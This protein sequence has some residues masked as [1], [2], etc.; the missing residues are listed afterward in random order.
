MGHSLTLRARPIWE[1]CLIGGVGMMT[2]R[3]MKPSVL[4]HSWE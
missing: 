1:T 3:P 4:G 2:L